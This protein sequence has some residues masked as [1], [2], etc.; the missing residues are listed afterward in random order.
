[1]IAIATTP[2]PSIHNQWYSF[3]SALV[4]PDVLDITIPS[5]G[6]VRTQVTIPSTP[7]LV[8]A[9]FRQQV[10]PFEGNPAGAVIAIT[11]TN[12]LLLTV[13]VL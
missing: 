3:R 13:G 4:T 7:A 11:S 6:L 5:A 8:G 10:V 2:P 1:M 9:Q 12:A